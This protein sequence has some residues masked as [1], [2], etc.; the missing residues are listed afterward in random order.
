MLGVNA[1]DYTGI[2]SGWLTVERLDGRM[3]DGHLAWICRCRC[4]STKRVSSHSLGRANP[5]KSCGCGNKV[6][7]LRKKKADGPWNEGKS[8]AIE[9]GGRCYKT[10]HSWSKAVLRHY[11]NKCQDCGWDAA[12]CDAHH[13]TL[14]SRDGRHT[15]ANGMVVCPNCHRIRHERGE[16]D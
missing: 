14:K 15:I 5:P 9:D 11:G 10:R 3:K 4:G 2:T 8:Y 13:R 6:T 7:A 16:C 12:R 1:R